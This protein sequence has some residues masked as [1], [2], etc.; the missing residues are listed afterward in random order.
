MAYIMPLSN[1]SLTQQTSSVQ[2]IVIV[3]RSGGLFSVTQ[4][5]CV[6]SLQDEW[7]SLDRPPEGI[8][9]QLVG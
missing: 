5:K 4:A 3:S 1:Y 2:I 9:D 8:I 6:T 7:N